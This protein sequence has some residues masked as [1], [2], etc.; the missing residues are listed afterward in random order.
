VSHSARLLGLAVGA[1]AGAAIVLG[2]AL[3]LAQGE[4][5]MQWIGYMFSIVGAVIIGFA[6][7]SG[8]PTSA[9]KH[10]ARRMRPSE[11]AA[12]TAVVAEPK[13]YVSE[14]VLLFAS[15]LLLVAA[16]TALELVI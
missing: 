9:R 4:S 14:V 3:G 10:V 13:A 12:D 15:G 2:L 7:F 6:C 8:A 11:D 16:G 5:V 1:G